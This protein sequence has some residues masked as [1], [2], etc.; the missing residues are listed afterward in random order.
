MQELVHSLAC[1]SQLTAASIAGI[2]TDTM[3]VRINPLNT[4]DPTFTMGPL[5]NVGA[6]LEGHQSICKSQHWKPWWPN[7]N[8]YSF[9]SIIGTISNRSR[10]TGL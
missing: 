10:T 7:R 1:N 8:N 5:G 3:N 2:N 4:P 6:G 9:R